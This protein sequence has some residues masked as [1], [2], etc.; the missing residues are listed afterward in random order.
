MQTHTPGPWIFTDCEK[1]FN[2]GLKPT[3][4]ITAS[5]KQIAEFSWNNDGAH[6]P[7]KEES[8][9]NARLIAAAPQL[10]EALI[11]FKAAVKTV[12]EMNHTRFDAL[13]IKV[14][15]AISRATKG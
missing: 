4:L 9:A 7:K 11:E 2:H 5:E 13:G 3:C 12:K 10:L 8:K 1:S 14:N 6:F 15:I